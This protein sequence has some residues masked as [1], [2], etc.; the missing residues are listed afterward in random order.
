MGEAEGGQFLKIPHGIFQTRNWNW[1]SDKIEVE[2]AE[3]V[4]FG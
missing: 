1:V 3:V 2:K 4:A